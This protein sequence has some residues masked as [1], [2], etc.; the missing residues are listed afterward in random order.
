[1][2]KTIRIAGIEFNANFLN[3]YLQKMF[4]ES[5]AH[6]SLSFEKVFTEGKIYT[7]KLLE[8]GSD[9]NS[10]YA[11]KL[12]EGN[13]DDL[14]LL[15]QRYQEVTQVLE[16][17]GMP[18][19]NSTSEEKPYCFYVEDFAQYLQGAIRPYRNKRELEQ[20]RINGELTGA[21]YEEETLMEKAT[22][23]FK[24]AYG[25]MQADQNAYN[26]K[27]GNNDGFMYGINCPKI[28][29]E[30][31]KEINKLV[32]SESGI[33]EGFKT[34]N[35]DILSA[36]FTPCPKELV[37][38]KMQELLWKYNNE[39]AEEIPEF[40]EGIDSSAQKNAYLK[41]ICEREAKF[42]IEFE[43]IH[44]FEDGNGRT[45]RII[46]N[47]QLIKNELAPI[48]ITPEMRHDYLEYINTNNYKEFGKLIF[49]LSSVT[50]S[51]LVA[52][53]RKIKGI[54]PEEIYIDTQPKTKI[55]GVKKLSLVIPSQENQQRMFPKQGK[56]DDMK[57][58]RIGQNKKN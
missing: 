24:L 22:T 48:L 21:S 58:Y 43:R 51:E 54:S 39:W 35:N 56:D 33:H 17:Y 16:Y 1:M 32:N 20:A 45:G 7:Q 9:E 34:S 29:I 26:L 19:K 47:S 36:S 12:N 11:I 2:A 10:E 53:Y 4:G 3:T 6:S 8:F 42:H 13:Q 55:T 5:F 49:M 44:P 15:A 57:I 27:K 18:R 52:Y 14:R 37:P 25:K 23:L 46:L 38:L 50:L 40:N 30:E 28:G 31:I 41:A